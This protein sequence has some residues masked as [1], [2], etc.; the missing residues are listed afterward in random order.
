MRQTE[1]PITLSRRH[2]WMR[3]TAVCLGRRLFPRKLT[4]ARCSLARAQNLNRGGHGLLVVMNH[5]STRD[6][7]EALRII[8]A[9]PILAERPILAP[10][11]YHQYGRYGRFIRLF[12]QCF[13]LRLI[14]IVTGDTIEK[15][16]AGLRRGLGVTEYLE[17]ATALLRCGG[18]VLLAPQGGRRPVLG[19]PPGSPVGHLLA[20]VRRCGVT[21]VALMP[22]GLGLP[23]VRDY[24][25]PGT[26]GFNFGRLYQVNVGRTLT[27]AEIRREVGQCHQLDHWL[28]DCLADLVPDAYLHPHGARPSPE[29]SVMPTGGAAP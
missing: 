4:D 26:R 9:S 3:K 23:G 21:N 12:A 7:L 25:A 16:G 22:I 6:S 20:R 17:S 11:A 5:F 2:I 15:L 14:P 24:S 8:F 27:V 18:I 1:A 10:V 13:N 19:S 28:F 29:T